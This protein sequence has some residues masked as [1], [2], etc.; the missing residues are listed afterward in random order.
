MSPNPHLQLSD[1]ELWDK[2]RS[3][4][5]RAFGVLYDRLWEP[6]YETAWWR[7]RDED[8]AKDIV[9][10]TFIHCW[11]QRATLLIRES[12]GAY[13]RSAV[14]R[15]VLNHLQ[16]AA[17]REKYT[18]LSGESL[19]VLSHDATEKVAARELESHYRAQLAQLPEAMRD[20]FTDSRELGLS[21][22]EIAE[23][24]RLSPQT[25]KNQLSGALKKMRKGLGQW[26][27]IF[28]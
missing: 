16:S 22:A 3:G 6:L 20:V 8:A 28:F 17:V 27:K 24:R 2:A 18:R 12:P 5:L 14:R 15:R 25:V 21:V 7:L 23:K 11:Q 1:P 4:D 26:L 9:Q 19:P 10:E 13:F